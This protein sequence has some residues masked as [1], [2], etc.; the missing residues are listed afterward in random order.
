MER[1]N[2]ILTI[3][4][5]GGQDYLRPLWRYYYHGA[6][7]FIFVVDSNDLSRMEEARREINKIVTEDEHKD[8][9]LLIFANKQDLPSALSVAD[10]TD[11]LQLHCLRNASWRIQATSAATGDG[12][13]DGLDWLIAQSKNAKR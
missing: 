3:Y 10:I 6:E 12:L 9:V 5:V 1:K 11:R 7:G 2:V 13:V 4:D 8:T